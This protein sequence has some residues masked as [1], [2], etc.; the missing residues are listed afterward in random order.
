M[1]AASLS[2]STPR[3]AISQLNEEMVGS[4]VEVS[5]TVMDLYEHRDGHLFVK[6]QDESCGA[7]TVPLFSD[8]RSGVGRIEALDRLV[9]RGEVSVY[10]GELEVI[11]SSPGDV[12]VLRVPPMPLTELN[13]N[14][15]G[16]LVKV[17]GRIT[18]I[19]YLS[20][21]QAIFTISGGGPSAKVF[22]PKNVASGAPWLAEDM[23]V[24]V[25]GWY[26]LY[27]GEPE[28]KVPICAFLSPADDNA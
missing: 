15:Y 5:G 23:V 9:V 28:I 6:L 27:N 3:L 4:T 14:R 12:T 26:Q 21:G 1:Y 16:T 10:K 18:N 7:L 24:R 13:E 2:M 19:S 22:L 11:P 8:M 25:G 20:G 17:E